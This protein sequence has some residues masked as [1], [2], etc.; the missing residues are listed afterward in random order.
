MRGRV[1]IEQ[2]VCKLVVFT[3]PH[4]QLF[5]MIVNNKHANENR[6]KND[7]NHTDRN[8]HVIANA[9]LPF[10]PSAPAAAAIHSVA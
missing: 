4:L 9:W 2:R 6:N 8:P 5:V 10:R 7:D 1:G 3:A